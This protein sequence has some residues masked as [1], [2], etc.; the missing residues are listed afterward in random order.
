ME[1]AMYVSEV[2]GINELSD[3]NMSI[4]PNPASG[5]VN[6]SF[7]A[8]EADYTVVIM[9]LQG[10][11]VTSEYKND[12]KGIQTITI[13]VSDLASGSYLVSVSSAKGKITKKVAIK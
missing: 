6:V 10:R 11:A 2:A 12:S 13:P 5:N 7:D 8:A 4:F 3:I 9:D 1:D